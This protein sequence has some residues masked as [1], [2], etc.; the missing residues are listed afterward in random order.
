MSIHAAVC[1]YRRKED[2]RDLVL[3]SNVSFWDQ[4]QVTSL[5]EIIIAHW[6]ISRDYITIFIFRERI[7]NEGGALKH[8]STSLNST[9]H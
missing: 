4:I 7:D 6:T 9:I 8:P 1:E 5:T 2:F 3:L